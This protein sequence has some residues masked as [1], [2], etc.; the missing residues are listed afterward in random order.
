[1]RRRDDARH[2][3]QRARILEV[4]QRCFAVGGFHQTGM[5]EICAAA[6]MSP[7]A[8]YRYFD[9]KQAIIEAMAEQERQDNRRALAPLA[10]AD[11]VIDGLLRVVAGLAPMWGSRAAGRLTLE[12]GAEA[13]RNDRIAEI[14]AAADADVRELLTAALRT[15]QE[16]GEV[17]RN[18]DP[19]ATAF[20]LIALVDGLIGR[21]A[22]PLPVPR[23]AVSAALADLI[24]RLLA[25]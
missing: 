16:R 3:R 15:G 7:G 12:V 21:G 25:P 24:R 14:F 20:V 5:A 17:R 4:A 6:G 9:S 1:M 10:T 13:A 22:F 23:K 18:L 11:N 8:L 19:A 2:S